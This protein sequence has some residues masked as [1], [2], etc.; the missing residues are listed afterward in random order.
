M[1]ILLTSGLALIAFI[2]CV[3]LLKSVRLVRPTQKGLVER[4][5]KYTRFSDQG[6]HLI[7][8]LIERMI[9]VDITE[10]IED[11]EQQEIITQDRLN[12]SIDAQIYFKVRPDEK[13]VKASQYNVQDYRYQIT[14]LAKTTLRNIIGNMSYQDANS[15]R[16]KINSDLQSILTKEAAPWG[17]EIVR[18]EIKELKPPKDVQDSMNTMIK[19]ENTKKAALDLATAAE[20]EADGRRRA[21]IKSADGEKQSQVLIADGKR[22]AIILEAAGQA[23]AIETVN[24]AVQKYFKN[25]AVTFKQLDVAQNALKRGTKIIVPE[26][27]SLVNVIS[28]AAGVLPI[29]MGKEGK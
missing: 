4:L 23:K 3:L 15:K 28:E 1:G 22:Q 19:A 26:G 27:A 12:A 25:E 29:V 16:H 24:T 10:N 6:F 14:S 7:V 17:L 8:P 9:R 2:A 13:S 20:T 21:A 5:G 18:T 11:V